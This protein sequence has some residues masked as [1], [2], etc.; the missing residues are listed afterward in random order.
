MTAEPA[1]RSKLIERLNDYTLVPCPQVKQK[2]HKYYGSHNGF[3]N[4]NKFMKFD[5]SAP[6]D[7]DQHSYR[8]WSAIKDS[9]LQLD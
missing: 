3:Y 6:A 8:K 7:Q 5:D 2:L 9:V 4:F 1:P